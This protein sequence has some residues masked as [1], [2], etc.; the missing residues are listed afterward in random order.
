MGFTLQSENVS[1]NVRLLTFP[2]VLKR[3]FYMLLMIYH[4]VN[5]AIAR[6]LEINLSLVRVSLNPFNE[7]SA[8]ARLDLAVE[9]AVADGAKAVA[10]GVI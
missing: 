1:G 10:C 2:A 6:C 5:R 7:E 3:V 9:D 8:T 4:R